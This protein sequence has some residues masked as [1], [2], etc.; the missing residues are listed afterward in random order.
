VQVSLTL[1]ELTNIVMV[2][3]QAVQ[4]GQKGQFVYIVTPDPTNSAIQ[5]VENRPVTTGITYHG[6][7]VVEKGLAAGETV[8]TDGQLRLAPGTMVNIKKSTSSAAA[9]AITN[10]P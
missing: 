5:I 1:S 10:S 7:T 4:T 2:P 6:E 9:T 3:S 8:V